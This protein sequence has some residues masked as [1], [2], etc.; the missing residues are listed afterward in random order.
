[1]RPAHCEQANQL[2]ASDRPPKLPWQAIW[3]LS[4]LFAAIDALIVFEL[5]WTDGWAVVVGLAQ[6]TA[7]PL[8]LEG[9]SAL[10]SHTEQRCDIRN[11]KY[12]LSA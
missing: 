11:L 10:N 8:S 3:P 7:G 2:P 9:L 6:M 12:F 1:M 5:I 4:D